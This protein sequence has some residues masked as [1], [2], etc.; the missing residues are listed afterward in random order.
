MLPNFVALSP[1][2]AIILAPVFNLNQGFIIITCM[3]LFCVHR[4]Q[5]SHVTVPDD[6]YTA[7]GLKK[8]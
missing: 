5:V 3:M 4:V 2:P 7:N 6:F 1:N 8:A